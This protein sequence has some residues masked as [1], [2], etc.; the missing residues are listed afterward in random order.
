MLWMKSLR[1]TQ[2]QGESL[3]KV[4][5]G[6]IAVCLCTELQFVFNKAPP[7][8]FVAESFQTSVQGRPEHCLTQVS[9]WRLELVQERHT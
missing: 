6:I 2:A 9:G 8:Y 1:D 3:G 4:G 5:I 7:V